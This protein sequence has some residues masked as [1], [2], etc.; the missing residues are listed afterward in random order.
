MMDDMRWMGF[1]WDDPISCCGKNETYLSQSDDLTA[2]KEALKKLYEGGFIYPSHATRGEIQR[3]VKE[4]EAASTTS[5][6][7]E[8]IF[9]MALRESCPTDL[10]DPFGME[11]V[12]WRFKVPYDSPLPVSFR[13]I[14][15]GPQVFEAGHD[16][17]DFVVWTKL[18]IPSYELAVVVDDAIEGVTEVV[19]GADL[20]LSTAR[21][22]LLYRALGLVIPDFFHCPL[23][24]DANGKRLAKSLNSEA[25]G[26]L[27]EAKYTPEE[28]RYTFFQIPPEELES[29]IE[30]KKM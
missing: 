11:G 3:A 12:N 2:Y 20:L 25:I 30:K 4:N 16:F 10:I 21:Q 26:S 19:R 13:D 5:R 23:V 15:Q 18:G 28:V 27:R 29:L 9:P 24:H 22:L 8:I 17:G 6:D 1:V 7:G 14:A